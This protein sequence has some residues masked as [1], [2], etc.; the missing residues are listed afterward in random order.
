MVNQ[1]LG[2]GFDIDT[3]TWK[4]GGT[5]RKIPRAVFP[6]VGRNIEKWFDNNSLTFFEVLGRGKR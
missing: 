5:Q 6:G 1:G 4:G 3:R 2:R